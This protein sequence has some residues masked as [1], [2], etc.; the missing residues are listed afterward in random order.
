MHASQLIQ[1]RAKVMMPC[2]QYDTL[3]ACCQTQRE[4][5]VA[6]N[7]DTDKGGSN[8][9]DKDQEYQDNSHECGTLKINLHQDTIDMFKSI[10]LF[11]QG[12]AEALYNNQ[13][14]TTLDV[15]REPDDDTIKDIACAIRKLGGDTQGDH[16]SEL[17]VSRLK[18]FAFWARHMWRT[19]RGVDDWTKTTWNDIQY[20]ASQKLLKDSLLDTNDPR[21]RPQPLTNNQLPRLLLTWWFTLARGGDNLQSPCL[22]SAL[23]FERTQ[24]RR[25]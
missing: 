14:F 10:L 25:H 5:G 13:M 22:C 3:Q 21:L 6:A 15:L 2:A 18:L 1:S 23:H 17:S 12:V 20:L 16:V 11:S 9:E 8:D 7:K 4:R 19:S 24:G